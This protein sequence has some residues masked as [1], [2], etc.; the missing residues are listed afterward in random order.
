M[1]H[2]AYTSDDM[3]KLASI[4]GLFE[5]TVKADTVW[6]ILPRVLHSLDV[7]EL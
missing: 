2:G 7:K 1:A 4:E 3:P 5:H 6:Q